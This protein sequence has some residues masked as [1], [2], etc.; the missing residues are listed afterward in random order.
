MFLR[1]TTNSVNQQHTQIKQKAIYRIIHI[2]PLKMIATQ[3]K[4]HKKLAVNLIN[5]ESSIK[6]KLQKKILLLILRIFKIIVF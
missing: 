3:V 2:L 5:K 6:N 4:I 1:G